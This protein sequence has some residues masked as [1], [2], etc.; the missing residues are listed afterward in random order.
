MAFNKSSKETKKPPKSQK[1]K[2]SYTV[3]K[4]TKRSSE[5]DFDESV[6]FGTSISDNKIIS[7]DRDN[8]E[9]VILHTFVGD[10]EL[11][12]PTSI[13]QFITNSLEL[14]GRSNDFIPWISSDFEIDNYIKDA[15]NESN[16]HVAFL[17][18]ID[19][20]GIISVEESEELI[21]K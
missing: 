10:Y 1:N 18:A 14:A 5:S 9:R 12:S 8:K 19:D 16:S 17:D 3:D 2:K 20:S 11:E 21:I 13:D 7:T 4:K 15:I 6:D